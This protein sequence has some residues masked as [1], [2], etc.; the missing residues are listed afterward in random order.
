VEKSIVV[1]HGVGDPLPGNALEKLIEGLTAAKWNVEQPLRIEHREEELVPTLTVA[2]Q[3]PLA[4]AR[5][6]SF[7][8]ARASLRK[9]ENTLNLTEVYWGDLSRPKGSLFGLVSALFDLIFGLRYIVTTATMQM[10][11]KTFG[12]WAGQL[13]RASLWWARGPLFALNIVAAAVCLVYVA[14]ASLQWSFL[15][16]RTPLSA[17]LVGGLGCA[18]LGWYVKRRAAQLQWSPATGEAM[19]AIGLLTALC[20]W[21]MRASLV[22]NLD[23][24]IGVAGAWT[25]LLTVTG[26]MIVFAA[27]MVSMA[28]LSLGCVLLSLGCV[29]LSAFSKPQRGQRSNG[30]PLTVVSF[31]MSLALGLFTFVVVAIWVLIA[32]TIREDTADRID[33]CLKGMPEHQLQCCLESRVLQTE[34]T[35]L[36]T[37]VEDGIHLLP[38]LVIGF[39][40]IALCFAG[41][42]WVNARRK[43]DP[44]RDRLRYIVHPVV[45]HVTVGFTFFYAMLFL[46][47]AWSI[48]TGGG[49]LP[50]WA[51]ADKLKPVA[52]AV[53]AALVVFVV[54]Q[55]SKFL[56]ALDLV[57]DVIAHFRTEDEKAD[58]TGGKHYVWNRIVKRFKDVVVH[59]LSKQGTPVIVIGHSQGTT[60]AAQGLGALAND[61]E[62]KIE[63]AQGTERVRLVTMGSPIQH[64]YGHYMPTRYKT[65]NKAVSAWLNIYRVD[66]YIGTK[67]SVAPFG[68]GVKDEPIGEGGHTDYWSD[69]RA[70]AHI[71]DMIERPQQ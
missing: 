50:E 23:R 11:E 20:G 49:K 39:G 6:P 34:G 26:A 2:P 24:F 27:V 54:A 5:K 12:R 19:I 16:G 71:V 1:V 37:R 22:E 3:K 21:L 70:I 68:E 28:L 46:W 59:E 7:P 18:A 15:S 13:A 40:L 69:S 65:T 64:L 17:I 33:R 10:D 55:Q 44:T 35:T 62:P 53:T 58:G 52:L 45:V 32:R 25:G 36:A 38:L 47:L 60:I 31:C 56:A 8:V 4:S 51:I 67:I 43:K 9:G 63:A 61:Y 42:M 14:I 30:G 48:V 29:L 57:L 41:V 66:D